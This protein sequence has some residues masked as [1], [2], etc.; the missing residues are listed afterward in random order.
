M[1][2]KNKKRILLL[3][4]GGTCILDKQGNVLS[5]ASRSDVHTW[6]RQMPEL[7]VLA[8]IYT[9]YVCSEDD[10]VGPKVWEEIARKIEENFLDFDGFVVVSKIDSLINTALATNFLLQHYHKSIIFTS[11]QI[12]GTVFTDKKNIINK[13]KDKNSGFGLRT[14]L[15]NAI[16]I[17]DQPFP[18]T[19][20]LFGTRIMPATKA[21]FDESGSINLFRSIDEDYWAKV[22]FGINMRPGLDVS[23][24]AAEIYKD[25][26]AKVFPFKD[27]PGTDWNIE[28]SFLDKYQAV[29]I[30]VSPYQELEETKKKKI[31]KWD[32]PVILYNYINS[33]FVEGATNL[34]NCTYSSALIK[35]MWAAANKKRVSDLPRTMQQNIIGE[36][37]N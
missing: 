2:R 9:E 12:S 13:L 24:K 30:E 10:V 33:P 31:L 20:I 25:I 17:A 6:Q 29:L 18:E 35:T 36:F 32:L 4:A 5:V 7:N 28:K 15:I 37:I 11:S 1:P 8:D 26:S 34:S 14:N 3:L 19:A 16:Q 21:V 22:D 23:S 27:I